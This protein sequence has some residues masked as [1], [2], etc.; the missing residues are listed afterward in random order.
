M[1]IINLLTRLETQITND[2]TRLRAFESSQRSPTEAP[3]LF[4]NVVHLRTGLDVLLERF[5]FYRTTDGAIDDR[6]IQATADRLFTQWTDERNRIITYFE[7]I[8][9]ILER[10]VGV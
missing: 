8:H 2:L 9:G 6:E 7:G 3:P 1:R 4:N 10:R 5:N